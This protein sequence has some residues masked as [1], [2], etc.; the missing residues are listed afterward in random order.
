MKRQIVLLVGLLLIPL[1]CGTA[2]ED[3]EDNQ[4]QDAS[5]FGDATLPG[6]GQ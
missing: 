6:D 1:G 2:P 4:G 3:G 5:L